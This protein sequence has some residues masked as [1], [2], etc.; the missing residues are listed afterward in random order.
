MLDRRVCIIQ[1][2]EDSGLPHH[3]V[4]YILAKQLDMKK[5]GSKKKLEEH[6]PYLPDFEP[7][8]YRLFPK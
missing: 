4:Y 2:V 8:D 6:P 1:T 5:M 3:V 7:N